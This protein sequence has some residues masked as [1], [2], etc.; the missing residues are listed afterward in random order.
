MSAVGEY[1]EARQAVRRASAIH[2]R[3]QMLLQAENAYLDA[4]TGERNRAVRFL[5][6]LEEERSEQQVSPVLM[7][8]IYT[9]LGNKERAQESLEKAWLKRDWAA[10]TLEQNPRLDPIR[11][12]PAY[13]NVIAKLR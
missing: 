8:E 1:G 9:A 3:R 7:A 5:S 6:R 2:N 4:K 13:R 11:N 12:T 10:A